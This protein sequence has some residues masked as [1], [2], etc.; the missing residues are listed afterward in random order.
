MLT[1]ILTIIIVVTS[2]NPFV[3]IL[4]QTFDRWIDRS[5][6]RE[7]GWRNRCRSVMAARGRG[8][9][10]GKCFFRAKERFL[11]R[12]RRSVCPPFV[13]ISFDFSRVSSILARGSQLIDDAT[14]CNLETWRNAGHMLENRRGRGR[15]KWFAFVKENWRNLRR[16]YTI[17]F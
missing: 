3:W 7:I 12:K 8:K 14:W 16:I 13:F 6:E 4:F 5:I 10:A 17:F 15:K 9:R 1:I 2:N 11:G